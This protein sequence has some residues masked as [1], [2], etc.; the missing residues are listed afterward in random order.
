M[1]VFT[2]IVKN[3]KRKAE[4]GKLFYLY[5][6]FGEEG[7]GILKSLGNLTIVFSR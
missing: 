1:L 6:D 5:Q 4:N 7:V 2:K 3:E